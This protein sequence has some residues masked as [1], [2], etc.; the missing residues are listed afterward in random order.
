[1]AETFLIPTPRADV[2]RTAPAHTVSTREHW[3]DLWTDQEYLYCNSVRWASGTVRPAA[4]LHWRYGEGMPAGTADFAYHERK[5]LLGHYVKISIEQEEGEDPLL[6]YGIITDDGRL[7]EGATEILD[8]LSKTGEQIL[9]AEGLDLLL[10]RTF[11]N[12]AWI[13]VPGGSEKQIQRGL[14]F[15]DPN[16]FDDSG[17]RSTSQLGDSYIFAGD[18]YDAHYWNTERILE[19]LLAYHGPRDALGE[20][21]ITLKLTDNAK[22]ILPDWDRPVVKTHGRSLRAVIDEL[23]NPGRLLSWRLTIEGEDPAIF[24]DVFPYLAAP[25]TLP[26]G[27]TQQANQN[28]VELGTEGLELD[29]AVDVRAALRDSDHD[30]VEQVIVRGARKRAVMT[31][32]HRDGPSRENGTLRADWTAAH[33]TDYETL[34]DEIAALSD[35]SDKQQ[36]LG[37]YRTKGDLQ[38]VFSWFRLPA[39]WDGSVGDGTGGQT[40]A[41]FAP[42]DPDAG[43]TET[44]YVPEMR[45]ERYLPKE[46]LDIAPVDSAKTFMPPLAFIREA[47]ESLV[48]G[49]RYVPIDQWGVS[50]AIEGTG[51]GA[52]RRWSASLRM[53]PDAPGVIVKVGRGKQYFLAKEDFSPIAGL[54]E[55]GQVDWQDLIVTVMVELDSYVTQRWPGR[56]QLDAG[57][58]AAR[59][60]YIDL[61]ESARLDW[62]HRLAIVAIQDGVA[63]YLGPGGVPGYSPT[64]DGQYVRDDREMM[65]DWARLV[66]ERFGAKREAF[67]IALKQLS[68]IVSVGD[69]I[70]KI[71]HGDTEETVNALVTG[72]TMDLLAGTTR[73][74]TGQ[75]EI[76][77]IQYV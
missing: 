43:L 58:D 66:F 10:M 17:N 31:L 3:A 18:L 27:K 54:D 48:H 55:P 36:R 62:V 25:L 30:R 34:P 74:T 47:D 14:T 51:D 12:S 28:L 5:S 29:R 65:L 19:Y 41:Y 77:P 8:A 26:S 22:A 57:A 73:I 33:E 52:G 61:G 59:V 49:V 71:G 6:W 44:F 64:S 32:G 67:T 40:K 45:F 70:T 1:M 72:V 53:Q 2:Y 63:Y 39:D 56:E 38:R 42:W 4:E 37:E 68:G 9:A 76:D 16:A 23:C 50:A 13:R 35:V 75:A 21:T 24:L 69:L 60:V 46:L 7:R 11:I 20:K 15:N